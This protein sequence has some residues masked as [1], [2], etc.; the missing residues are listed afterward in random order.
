MTPTERSPHRIGLVGCVKTKANSAQLAKDLYLSP[1]FIGRR[2]FVEITCD[3]WW[4]LSALHG[5]VHPDDRIEPYDVAL[6]NSSRL[7][8]Q[9]WSQT[10][11]ASIDDEVD[12][13]EGDTFEFH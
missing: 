5:L 2:R 12:S 9:R 1:L 4:I 3:E 11:L 7:E 10:V 6:V 8:K 13:R